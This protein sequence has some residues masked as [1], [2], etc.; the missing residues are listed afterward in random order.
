M[1]QRQQRLARRP[2]QELLRVVQV[3]A[4]SQGFGFLDFQ[5]VPAE[6]SQIEVRVV[7][8][9]LAGP[10]LVDIRQIPDEAVDGPG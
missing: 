8:P 9:E 10:D 7:H 6:F 2:V 3:Q 5:N 4:F 1:H